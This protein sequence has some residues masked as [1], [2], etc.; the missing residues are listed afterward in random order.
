MSS[1]KQHKQLCENI[2]F[3]I[4]FSSLGEVKK[5]FFFTSNNFYKNL[6]KSRFPL[7]LLFLS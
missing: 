2:L 7:L 4:F 5:S 1:Y 3:Y 6:L